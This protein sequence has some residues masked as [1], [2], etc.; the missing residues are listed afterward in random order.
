MTTN[1]DGI[2]IHAHAV[3]KLFLEEVKRTRLG[4]VDVTAADKG[5][6]IV[7]FPGCAPLRPA[8]GNMLD[9]TQ[10]LAWLDTQGMDAAVDRAVAGRARAGT[11]RPPTVRCGCER[12]MTRWRS[13]SPIPEIVCWHMP[14]SIWPSRRQPRASSNAVCGS[15]A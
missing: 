7:T 12:S 11:C 8:A 10:R 3:P 9:F 4:G 2:D 15:S 14:R 5:G 6:Y 13:R 1:I